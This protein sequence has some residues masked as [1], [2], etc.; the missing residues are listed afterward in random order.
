MLQLNKSQTLNTIAFYPDIAVDS[1]V[2]LLLL[3][4]SQDYGKSGS[5]FTAAVTSNPNVTPWVIARFS[6][7]ILPNATGFYTYDIYE[8]TTGSALIWNLTNTQWQAEATTWD[9]SGSVTIGD[10][11]VTTRAFISG[12]DVEPI[13]QY[14]SPDENGAYTVYLG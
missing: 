7:S 5:S 6:G 1:S 11:L 13:T 12:S 8:Y 10:K 2:T 4:G 14:V 3:S 9:A